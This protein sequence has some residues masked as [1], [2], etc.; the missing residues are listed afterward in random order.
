MTK[1]ICVS[2]LIASFV[3]LDLYS[4]SLLKNLSTTENRISSIKNLIAEEE[5]LYSSNGLMEASSVFSLTENDEAK[6][7]ETVLKE[8]GITD[9]SMNSSEDGEGSR[10]Y[11][12]RASE[13]VFEKLC[14]L[15]NESLQNFLIRGFI[16]NKSDSDFLSLKIKTEDKKCRVFSSEGTGFIKNIFP[17]KAA[18][19]AID[20]KKKTIGQPSLKSEVPEQTEEPF[21]SEVP[22]QIQSQP[23]IQTQSQTKSREEPLKENF[24]VLG[25][26]NTEEDFIYIK[27]L[28]NE[29]IMKIKKNDFDFEKG[30]LK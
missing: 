6:S 10:H 2:F 19:S 15:L 18:V 22:E 13:E 20:E 3:F 11:S 5:K 29:K 23:Q 21:R 1:K 14:I 30:E 7:F 4:L 8:S 24:A 17:E 9:F 12:F 25:T 27:S 16:L 26:V 28:Q